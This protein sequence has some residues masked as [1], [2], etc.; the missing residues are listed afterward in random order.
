[1]FLWNVT[2]VCCTSHTV[3]FYVWVWPMEK[4]CFK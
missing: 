4:Y 2:T 1:M 3:L